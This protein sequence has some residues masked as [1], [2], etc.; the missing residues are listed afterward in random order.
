MEGRGDA[1]DHTVLV[2]RGQ[3]Q[4]GVI[5]VPGFGQAL[6]RDGKPVLNGELPDVS[7]PW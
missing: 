7:A 6:G 5:T 3:H 2:M 4:N 1:R